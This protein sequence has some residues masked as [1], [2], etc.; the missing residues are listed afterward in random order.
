MSH[1]RLYA[2]HTIYIHT[3]IYTYIHTY[4]S[5]KCL[6]FIYLLIF[7][8]YVYE[9]ETNEC[10]ATTTKK[11]N[12]KSLFDE[13]TGD[14]NQYINIRKY[15]YYTKGNSSNYSNRSYWLSWGIHSEKDRK[16]TKKYTLSFP[17]LP[18][19][20]TA[21]TKKPIPTFYHCRPLK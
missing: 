10:V 13:F 20:P 18:S 19:L 11:Q 3:Y 9:H 12:T 14:V 15:S 8:L 4:L 7:Y 16:Q 6:S 2:L 5:S 21:T 17:S 1:Y